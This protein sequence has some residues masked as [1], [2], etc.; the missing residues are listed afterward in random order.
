MKKT[1][2]KLLLWLCALIVIGAKAQ[3]VPNVDWVKDYSYRNNIRNSVAALDANNNVY[4]TGAAYNGSDED[5][6]V[7]K[8]DSLGIL[9][10]SYLYNNGAN[11]EGNSVKVDNAGNAFVTGV[12]Y[13]GTTGKDYITIKLNPTGSVVWTERFNNPN[14]GNG[15]D[16]GIDLVLDDANDLVYVTGESYSGNANTDITTVTYKKSTGGIQWL[17]DYNGAGN[18]YDYP[19]AI[20]IS[21]NG[22]GVFVTGA[23]SGSS[24]DIVTMYLDLN[25]N[26]IWNTVTDGT[27]GGTDAGNA[28]VLSGANVVVCGVIDNTTTNNDYTTIK[29][30]GSNGS[31]IWQQNYDNSNHWNQATGLAKDSTGNI[32]VVGLELNGSSIYEYRTIMY[33]STGTQLWVNTESTGLSVLGT[34]P[35]IA[36][37]T[38]ADHFYISGQIQKSNRDIFVYQVDPTGTTRWKKSV[39]GTG[40]GI[41]AGVNISVKTFGIIYV[42]ANTEKTGGGYDITTVKISQTP[43]YFPLDPSNE[44]PASDKLFFANKGQVKDTSNVAV[45][46]IEYYNHMTSPEYY[47]K[48]TRVSYVFSKSD[49]TALDSIERMDVEFYH[50]NKLADIYN[51]EDAPTRL[52]YFLSHL[53]STGITGIIGSKRLFIPNL[54]P[55]IDLHYYSNP[56]GIKYYFVVKPFIG[57][58]STAK[59]QI[60]GAQSTTISSGNLKLMG[61]LGTAEIGNVQA[62]E[63]TQ[64]LTTNTISASWNALSTNLYG[65]TVGAYTPTLPL[66]IMVSKPSGIPA[67]SS[68]NQNMNYSTFYGGTGGEYFND[69]NVS[70]VT[71][72]RYISGVAN[73][74][75]FPTAFGVFPWGGGNRDAVLLSYNGGDTLLCAT[76]FGGTGDDSGIGVRVK[77]NGNVY[78]VGNTNSTNLPIN[79][80]Q[81][82]TADNQSANGYYNLSTYSDKKD[83]F[84][85]ELAENGPAYSHKW[86]RYFGGIIIDELSDVAMDN[87]DNLYFVGK[88]NSCNYPKKFSLKSGP[89]QCQYGTNYDMVVTKMDST[90]KL[91]FSTYYGGDTHSSGCAQCATINID[92][93]STVDVDTLGNIYV[94]GTIWSATNDLSPVNLT[95]NTATTS[96]YNPTMGFGGSVLLRFTINKTLDFASELGRSGT[97]INDIKVLPNQNVILGGG[98]QDSVLYFPLK[99]SGTS[100]YRSIPLTTSYKG[101]IAMVDSNLNNLW[102]THFNRLNVYG[103]GEVDVQRIAVGSDNSFYVGG[104]SYYDSLQFV[105]SPPS[106]AY[107]KTTHSVQEGWISY[108]S[109]FSNVYKL[110]HTHFLG[111]NSLDGVNG[112]DVY[113]KDALY[114]TGFTYSSNYPVAYTSANASL[115]D[116]SWNGG[117]DGFVTRFDLSSVI[118]S[119]KE[120]T[121]D[122]KDNAFIK[123]YPN[124]VENEFF[125]NTSDLGN[126][127]NMKVQVY[128]MVGQ[129]IK[130]EKF[131]NFNDNLIKVDCN[132]WTHGIYLIS[133]VT[134]TQTFSGKVIKP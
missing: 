131:T 46:D 134:D 48:N 117:Q 68:T 79:T 1:K 62:Y 81:R 96:I 21:P 40:N 112:L 73:S 127:K 13:D 69:I 105:S 10:Y 51:Y 57:N 63:I 116:N 14:G 7:L 132:N 54:Y 120:N 78:L 58:V 74:N 2:Q 43:V 113:K 107:S 88:S 82:P 25:G 106:G 42:I 110:E 53:D 119:V 31:I 77:A 12:S 67:S 3:V 16:L 59:L 27:A 130:E 30:D 128:N 83:G 71:N 114:A 26:L 75:A 108:F 17:Y 34:Y 111:G 115:I 38:I 84:V 104:T 99:Q 6:V 9:Q 18:G 100:F 118:I 89:S 101:Y 64:N 44:P 56:N 72:K 36:M 15:D 123:A 91:V 95:G 5:L 129:L 66:V 32:A 92:A 37:D 85:L 4:V 125:I 124:P 28:I 80:A 97:S 87:K 22:S 20:T 61:A 109:N 39:N 33:D 29:Y 19:T 121:K 86:S 103:S 41:D 8:Y 52:N 49:T 76:F 60:N 23:E 35:K 11:D 47:I 65:F 90:C 122:T 55:G 98:T 45:N 126:T 50:A 133:V 102:C 93:A 94:G 24:M 70:D